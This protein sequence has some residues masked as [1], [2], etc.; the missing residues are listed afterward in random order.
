M[1]QISIVGRIA[2]NAEIKEFSNNKF[3]SFSVAVDDGFG[4]KKKTIWFECEYYNTNVC[5]HIRGGDPIAVSGEFKVRDYND[6]T[7][8]KVKANALKLL[9]SKKRELNRYAEGD[10][11]SDKNEEKIDQDMDDEIPF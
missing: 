10:N 9:G 7:Y 6:K 5:D 3:V 1:K 2:K 8:F 11:L 4:D